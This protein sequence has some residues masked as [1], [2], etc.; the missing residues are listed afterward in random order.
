MSGNGEGAT[1]GTAQ[2]GKLLAHAYQ[3]EMEAQE[4]Y[5][6]LADQ[7]EVHNNPH[8]EKLFRELARVE[9]LHAQDILEEMKNR[10]VPELT[11]L[12]YEWSGDDSP[13]AVDF[14]AVR[15]Q[16]VPWQALQLALKAEQNA[17]NFFEEFSR[18]TDDP[19]TKRFADEFA[20]EEKEH[21]EL[22]LQLLEKYPEPKGELIEDLD[23]PTGQD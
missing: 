17:Q 16:M 9:G 22:V 8:L 13:E 7:M 11:A 18:S 19:D 23:P 1:S 14:T 6:M 20:E 12:Q 10:D 4:R 21:V 15:H 5:E 2:L 3:M